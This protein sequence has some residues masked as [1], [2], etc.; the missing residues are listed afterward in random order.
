VD[1]KNPPSPHLH[2]NNKTSADFSGGFILPICFTQEK[3][4]KKPG[5]TMKNLSF[6]I[7]L[8]LIYT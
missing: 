8:S 7:T 4:K 6:F 2:Q 3:A 1:L 5:E